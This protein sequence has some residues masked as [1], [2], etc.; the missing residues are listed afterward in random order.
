MYHFC[1][2]FEDF[3]WGGAKPSPHVPPPTL[4][5]PYSQFLDP[6]LAL[7]TGKLLYSDVCYW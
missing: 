6:P 5:P 7:I 3:F 2:K 1:L 4:S